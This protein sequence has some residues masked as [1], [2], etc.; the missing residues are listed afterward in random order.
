MLREKSPV[1]R[2]ISVANILFL[3][4]LSFLTLFIFLQIF[5]RLDQ[6]LL[7]NDEAETAIYGERILEFGYP[8]IRD[9]KNTLYLLCPWE[10]KGSWVHSQAYVGSGWFQYYVAAI[11]V[12]M[13]RNSAENQMKTLHVRLPFAFIGGISLI[14]FTWWLYRISGNCKSICLIFLFLASFH[15]Q[16]MLYLREARYYALISA[17]LACLLI[18]VFHPSQRVRTF[19]FPIMIWLNFNIFYPLSLLGYVFFGGYYLVLGHFDKKALPYLKCVFVTAIGLIPLFIF[20]KILSCQQA[21]KSIFNGTSYFQNLKF[22]LNSLFQIDYWILMAGSFC[23]LCLLA[24]FS[25]PHTLSNNRIRTTCVLSGFLITFIILSCF[26]HIIFI[27]YFLVVHILS[28]IIISLILN[29]CLIRLSKEKNLTVRV[30]AIMLIFISAILE[31]RL[32]HN[33]HSPIQLIR[34]QNQIYTGP[35]DI[36]IPFIQQQFPNT[37]DL[38]IATNIEEPCYMYYLKSKVIMGLMKVE[39]QKDLIQKPDIIIFRKQHNYFFGLEGELPHLEIF[40]HYASSGDYK[41]FSFDII[42]LQFNQF[43]S[44]TGDPVHLFETSNTPDE[45]K[46]LYILILQSLIGSPA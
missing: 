14:C 35:I 5:N 44:L 18:I 17:G 32:H 27:R 30:S 34:S 39:Y 13:A 36:L 3:I 9:H 41:A 12:A 19:L 11:G 10:D 21:L 4:C 24:Y 33:F 22:T 26:A 43:P 8:K 6:P 37:P 42:D 2:N 29:E 25:K 16:W 23:S 7:W 46:K 38:T 15:T 28:M 40:K 1:P 20:Y 45:D 31:I